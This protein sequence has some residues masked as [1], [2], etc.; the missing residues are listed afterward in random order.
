MKTKLLKLNS[1]KKED[2]DLVYLIS[3]EENSKVPSILK[4]DVQKENELALNTLLKSNYSNN[5]RKMLVELIVS[6]DSTNREISILAKKA[7]KEVKAEKAEK[8]ALIFASEDAKKS[9]TQFIKRMIVSLD[10][11]DTYKTNG[12]ENSKV[13]SKSKPG[14]SL[15]VYSNNDHFDDVFNEAV[16]TADAV[17]FAKYLVNEPANIMS[18]TKLANEAKKMSEKNGIDVEIKTQ[19]EIEALKMDAFLAVSRASVQ[20]PRLIIM[21]YM[22]NKESDET[23]GLIGK[24]VTYDSGGL[25]IKPAKGMLTMHADMGGSA[26]VIGAINLLASTNAKVNA[27]AVV[28]A[29]E[30]M[31]SGD[32]FRNGDIISSMSGKNIEIINTDAEGR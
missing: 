18:P 28:A 27:I 13:E 2:Y 21:R 19:E 4:D 32:A 25:A 8:I 24:G 10:E 11:F 12:I 29:C 23:I 9:H 14:L 17:N 3:D 7:S 15:D 31:I 6:K 26:A 20:E 30:N 5:P 16:K 1:F 22:N